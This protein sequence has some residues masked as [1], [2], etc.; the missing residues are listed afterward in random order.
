MP[1]TPEGWTL[2]KTWE[3]CR[4][5]AYPDPASGGAAG[6]GANVNGGVNRVGRR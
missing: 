1:L 3:G 6:R 5:S 2:P 4:L